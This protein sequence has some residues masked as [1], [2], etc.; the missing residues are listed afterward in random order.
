MRIAMHA[1]ASAPPSGSAGR[2]ASSSKTKAGERHVAPPVPRFGRLEA[3]ALGHRPEDPDPRGGT[4]RSRCGRTFVRARALVV[5]L[6]TTAAL[7]VAAAP[8]AAQSVQLAPFGGQNFSSP[9]DVTGAPGDP[10]RAC[11]VEGAGTIRL[12]KN[13]VTQAT[14]F[15]DLS[16]A[17]YRG[18]GCA[19]SD[20]G[21]FSMALA[22]DY[23]TSGLF[24]VF[25]TRAPTGS[26]AF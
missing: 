21:L 22:P 23:A 10:S 3:P 13:G 19:F 15:L 6:A 5:G 12:V 26:E 11:V 1:S 14:P 18:S 8:A 16:S 17:V 4:I 25:Y 2:W 7:L 9:Y 24:Y 20:C